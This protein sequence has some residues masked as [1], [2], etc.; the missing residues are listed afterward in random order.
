MIMNSKI[1]TYR[2]SDRKRNSQ[3]I[4]ANS[5]YLQ[6]KERFSKVPKLRGRKKLESDENKRLAPYAV[7]SASSKGRKYYEKNDEYRL[8]FQKDRDRII[9]SKAFRRLKGKTQVFVE[10]YGDHFRTRLTHTLE[11]AQISRDISRTLGLNEDLAESIALAHDLGHTPF[12]HAGE[13]ALDECLKAYGL[14]FEHNEQSKRIVEELEELYPNF[15]GLNLSIEVLEGLMKHQTSWDHPRINEKNTRALFS[16]PSLEAQVVN[17]ADEIAYHTHDI[18]DGLR[19]HLI[20]WKDVELLDIFREA[21]LKVKKQYGIMTNTHIKRSRMVSAMI[22]LM[23]NDLCEA[24]AKNIQT[25]DIQT[26]S[27]VY[28]ANK[29]IVSFSKK[30]LRKITTC[31]QFLIKKLYFHPFVF[32]AAEKGKSIIRDIF[33][34]YKKNVNLLPKKFQ[35]KIHDGH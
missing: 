29:Q 19:S 21:A 23:V 22:S 4:A 33:S 10:H 18:D 5:L 31:K 26:I 3:D 12:G 13:D 11:V 17:L 6:S 34:E 9:H 28:K 2:K 1:A 25:H 35:K 30:M 24:T 16:S 14:H 15:S 27:G 8:C 32:E 20:Q 7:K